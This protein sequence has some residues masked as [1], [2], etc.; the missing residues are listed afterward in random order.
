[1]DAPII[2][3]PRGEKKDAR[4][5]AIR[6]FPFGVLWFVQR[7]DIIP[8]MVTWKFTLFSYNTNML[9]TSDQ[10]NLLSLDIRS[11]IFLQGPGGSGKTTAGTQW[12]KKL[13]EAGIP[14]H[15]ILVFVPQRTLAVPYQEVVAGASIEAHGVINAV[16]LGGLARRMVDTFWPLV[17][18][19]AGFTEPNKPPNFLTLETAQ[20]YMAHL[21]RRLIDQEGLFESLAINRNRIYA[22][23]LDNLN[24]AA[25]VGFSHE[26]IGGRLKSAW[27]GDIEQLHIYDDVQFCADQFRKF[28]LENNLLDFSLQ[29]EIFLK[30]LWPSSMVR[31]HLVQ[32]YRHLIVDNIEEDTPVSHDVLKSW[33]PEFESALIIFD[34][35][36]GYRTFLGADVESALSLKKSCDQTLRFS[37]NLVPDESIKHVAH[38]IQNAIARLEGSSEPN[39]EPPF[40]SV[41]SA[42]VAPESNPKY[43]PE[44]VSWVADQISILL[45]G[46]VLPGEIVVLA[47]FM[48][49]VLRFALSN[50]L[51]ELGIPNKSHRPS[52]PLRDEPATQTVLTL[53][54]LAFHSWDLLPKRINLAFALMQV[55]DGLDLVRGQLLT[56]YTYKKS[57]DGFRL[58]PFEEVP[59]GIRDRITYSA[60]EKFDRLRKWLASVENQDSLPLDF[61]LN[62]LFGEVLSQ[63]G[64]GFHNDL[65]GGNTV[66]TLIESIQK[67]RWA[68]GDGFVTD[69]HSLGKE[70]IQMV[71]EGVIAAQYIKSWETDFDDAVLLSPAYTF[72][73][74]NRPVDI[75]FWLD[76]G[77]PSW[78]QRLDQ[79][80]THPYVLS[81]DWEQGE[82]WDAE[83]ELAASYQS[84]KRL[85]LGLLNRCRKKVY[86]GM[87]EL[88]VRGYENR[89]LLIRVIQNV[90][91][92]AKRR[93]P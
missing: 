36:A 11:K 37:Q 83:D 30:H 14:P 9:L 23:I 78:Y 57:G 21:V 74:S 84:L 32:S 67:F 77:S 63:P 47:P 6:S 28:C 76:I 89:G 16:T 13:I 93:S 88:D 41:R 72:L 4:S 35:N 58:R 82:V 27:V 75:Q 43:F 61:F 39:P 42:L 34:E 25:V 87:S 29:V 69:E 5:L 68:I 46:G 51:D 17:S 12:L 85:S 3:T 2:A 64:Y 48:P 70:Y 10:E 81:R 33:L 31:S 8:E 44:M 71:D 50:R 38:G 26:E 55:I 24:K 15:E 53:A 60:G 62:K 56:A 65:D 73:M 54:R 79:P 7:L 80:L 1:M 52:R 49:D 59:P 45:D 20:Y 40:E 92:H 90:L 91:Q 19:D 86:L 18:Q 66:A 22:Q